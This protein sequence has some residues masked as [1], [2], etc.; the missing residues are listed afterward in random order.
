MNDELSNEAVGKRVAA[1][2]DAKPKYDGF[3]L[4]LRAQIEKL[5]S[6]ELE[7]VAILRRLDAGEPIQPNDPLH[8]LLR[9]T[10]D[11]MLSR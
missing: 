4:P 10:Y 6:L 8:F 5:I 11:R 2:H 1:D 9:R 3:G 7:V